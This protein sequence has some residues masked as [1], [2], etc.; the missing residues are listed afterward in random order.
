MNRQEMQKL[1]EEVKAN[2][3]RLKLCTLHQFPAYPPLKSQGSRSLPVRHL[4]CIRC[5][6]QVD[7]INAIYYVRGYVAAGGNAEQIIPN[8]SEH[9][10]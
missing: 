10:Q 5:G 3:A 9:E 6:G 1:I 8:W 2:T 7:V 4:T